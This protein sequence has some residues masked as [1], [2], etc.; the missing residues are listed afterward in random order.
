MGFSDYDK[1][2]IKNLHYSAWNS[3]WDFFNDTEYSLWTDNVDF[4]QIC[5]IQ[6]DLF[7]CSI[8]NYEIMLSVLANTFSFILQGSAL[9]DL[10]FGGRFLPCDAMHSAAI[11]GMQ[12]PSV[13]LFVRLSVMFVSCTKTNKDIFEIFLPF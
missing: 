9:A 13:C 4:V 7:D 11:A 8:F 1:I 12:C 5:Y 3:L 10:G 6:C 2:L